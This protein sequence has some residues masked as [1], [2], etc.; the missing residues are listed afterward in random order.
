RTTA[1]AVIVVGA[2]AVIAAVIM[3]VMLRRSLTAGVRAT[4]I[5][6]ARSVA[7]QLEQGG[8]L[9]S[10][11]SDAEELDTDAEEEEFFQLLTPDGELIASTDNVMPPQ[12]LVVRLEPGETRR[13]E[14]VPVPHDPGEANPFVVVAR[15]LDEGTR[16]LVAGR[17]LESVTEATEAVT[18]LLWI[19]V[20][21]LLVVV[22]GVTW[23]VT[24]RALAPVDA[25]RAEV[26]TIST[27][28][29]H[30]RVPQPASKDEIA[31][32]AATMN[33]MLGRLERGQA[34]QRRFV[35]DASHELRSPVTTIRQHAEV[36]RQH[37][38]GTTIEELAEV[39]L[40]E[41][42]RLQRLVEDLLLLA[43]LDEGTL[44]LR[45]QAVDL[46]DLV[47]EEAERLRATT[48]LR[49]DPTGVSAGRV[50]GD[51]GQLTRLVR[52]LTDNAARHAR[53]TIALS[54][55]EER[56]GIVLGVEDDGSGIPPSDRGRV[57]ERFERLDEARDRDSGGS[58]LGLAIVAEVAAAHGASVDV[59]DGALGGAR[60]EVRFPVV[61]GESPAFQRRLRRGV[62]DSQAE[63]QSRRG[64]WKT[65]ERWSERRS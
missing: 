20:P 26:E 6:H 2:A 10:L 54:L 4:A 19:G 21:L 61:R 55:R 60:F 18:E 1:A 8:K 12:Q 35:S 63:T 50:L 37:P 28:Q 40:E 39:V 7:V 51:A 56:D 17:T 24:G 41:D 36:A 47:F 3:V 49:V 15:A 9:P 52:N 13:L 42:A 30:R 23:H 11:D 34:R 16:I 64:R 33:L 38:K 27:N 43:K 57:F 53:T 46:D 48:G 59:T 14:R 31:R 62:A 29:L 25:M 65:E 32:L 22:G 45:R 5:L 58:G 44:E